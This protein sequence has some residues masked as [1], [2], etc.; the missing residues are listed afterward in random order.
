M[1]KILEL[2]ELVAVG[3]GGNGA[4]YYMVTGN[5]MLEQ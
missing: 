1:V 2:V 3:G 4:Y 5:L